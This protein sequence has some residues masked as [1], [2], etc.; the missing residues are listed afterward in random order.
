M[1]INVKTYALIDKYLGRDLFENE[2]HELYAKIE[3]LNHDL[4][5]TGFKILEELGYT[6]EWVKHEETGKRNWLRISF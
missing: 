1:K 5:K 2:R 3:K 6:I 4:G